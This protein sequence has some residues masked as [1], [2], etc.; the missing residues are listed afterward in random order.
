MY[1]FLKVLSKIICQNKK[2]LILYFTKCR[3]KD[4]Y[5]SV[6]KGETG[7]LHSY[8]VFQ[9]G[10]NIYERERRFVNAPGEDNFETSFASI[11]GW[12][13]RTFDS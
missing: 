5:V 1:V 10:I 8:S 13:N 7:T 2:C 9:L 6:N 11:P 12:S 4:Q 3:Q